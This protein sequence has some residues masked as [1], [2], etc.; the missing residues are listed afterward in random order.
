MMSEKQQALSFDEKDVISFR[1]GLFGF[2]EYKRFLPLSI[3]EEDE[4][5]DMLYL[6]SVDEVHL[7][8][9]LMNPFLLKEDYEPALSDADRSE[10]AAEKDDE[11]AYYVICV[12]KD[13]PD[14]STVNL[15]CPIV[16][17]VETRQARQVMLEQDAYGLH[18]A[19]RE[20]VDKEG[21]VC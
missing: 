8:F 17:N 15:K 2:E 10:L 18:H 13:T 3:D 19:L 9:L 11:L 1:E 6:Q 16:I 20:F 5:G 4:S 12:I 21:A 14:E 7:S